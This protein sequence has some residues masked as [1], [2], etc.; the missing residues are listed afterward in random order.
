MKGQLA[1]VPRRRAEVRVGCNAARVVDL[2]ERED[3]QVG[4][5]AF[6]VMTVDAEAVRRRERW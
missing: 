5:C 4:T 6:G 2:A 1:V 3:V